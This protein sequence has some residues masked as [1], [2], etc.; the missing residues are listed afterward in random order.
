MTVS[1]RHVSRRTLVLCSLVNYRTSPLWI[2]LLDSYRN[3]V[4]VVEEVEICHTAG[5]VNCMNLQSDIRAW[6]LKT[7]C[8]TTL[9]HV[10]CILYASGIIKCRSVMCLNEKKWPK[11]TWIIHISK[12]LFAT[13]TMISFCYWTSSNKYCIYSIE[14]G[15]QWRH[16]DK[17]GFERL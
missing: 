14:P 17:H 7:F 3:S 11:T 13:S 5:A 9:L 4:F 6:K 12:I 2:L 15:L 16:L 1:K 10:M 8:Y